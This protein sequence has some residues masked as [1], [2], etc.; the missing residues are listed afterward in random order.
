MMRQGIKVSAW[1]NK[2]VGWIGLDETE[3][4]IE[5]RDSV[6]SNTNMT[7]A[8]ARELARQLYRLARRIEKRKEVTT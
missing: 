8:E 4:R 3:N 6:Y 1:Y 5:F 7:P 2:Q